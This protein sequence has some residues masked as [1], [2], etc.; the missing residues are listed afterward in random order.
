MYGDIDRILIDRDAIADRVEQLAEG[1]VRDLG[2]V[3]DA[4]D[5]IVMPIM[6]GSLFFTADLVR[7]LPLPFRILP[8]TI[9]SYPGRST[10]SQGIVETASLPSGIEG[11]TV[12]IVD[13]I[14]D[15]GRTLA[16]LRQR[17][18]D[19]GAASSCSCVLLRKDVPRAE[20]VSCEYVG[21]DIPEVFVV[22][23]G[24]DFDGLY[25]NL[26]DIAVLRDQVIG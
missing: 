6:T 17:L 25:R 7:R 11:A 8:T 9:R 19:A 14:L 24:L 22:G 23:Y 18:L 12:L 3:A 16:H 5:L 13:D 10:T 20:D 15:S 26:P 2:A 1:L 21:F 4:G